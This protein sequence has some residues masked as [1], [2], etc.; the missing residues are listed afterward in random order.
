[1]H[2]LCRS[3]LDARRLEAVARGDASALEDVLY[4]LL[5]DGD[6]LEVVGEPVALPAPARRLLVAREFAEPGGALP[7]VVACAD[8]S[9]LAGSAR[10]EGGVQLP[11]RLSLARHDP[12]RRELQQVLA[13]R[14]PYS[15]AFVVLIVTLDADDLSQLDLYRCTYRAAGRSVHF[16]P[17]L[18]GQGMMGVVRAIEPR[19]PLPALWARSVVDSRTARQSGADLQ[20]LLRRHRA[21]LPRSTRLGRPVALASSVAGDVAVGWSDG[22][23]TRETGGVGGVEVALDLGERLRSVDILAASG[24]AGPS[25]SPGSLVVCTDDGVVHL[26]SGGEQTATYAGV[27]PISAWAQEGLVVLCSGSSM[28]LGAPRRAAPLR[29]QA[30]LALDE[31]LGGRWGQWI[32][33]E[34]DSARAIARLVCWIEAAEE[35]VVWPVGLRERVNQV[36]A[37]GESVLL[38]MRDGREPLRSATRWPPRSMARRPR[39]GRGASRRRSSVGSRWAAA[40]TSMARRSGSSCRSWVGAAA[41]CSCAPGSGRSRSLRRPVMQRRPGARR[42]TRWWWRAVAAHGGCCPPVRAGWS[43]RSTAPTGRCSR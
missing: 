30:L 14:Q 15:H 43:S 18:D 24:G 38:G 40:G 6:V 39:P 7:V 37:H 9:V 27:Q 4:E 17:A 8:G 33:G 3:G 5:E 22:R 2:S 41:G 28:V 10:P 11:R 26:L 21:A 19:L 1:M 23:V 12:N 35:S 20:A 16:A 34:R 42:C 32:D 13:V 31:A 29:R 25:R 36:A